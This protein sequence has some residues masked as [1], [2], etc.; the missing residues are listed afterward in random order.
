MQVKQIATILNQTIVPE[1]TGS[2]DAVL[3]EDLSNIVTIG[4]AVD[5]YLAVGS[6]VDNAVKK[7]ICSDFLC[8]SS[9][10]R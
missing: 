9:L 8:Q 2:A 1:A 7:I 3:N 4:Q 5:Q 10:V 6:N